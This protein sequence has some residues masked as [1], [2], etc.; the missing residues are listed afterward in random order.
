MVFFKAK[1][2]CSRSN[3]NYNTGTIFRNDIVIITKKKVHEIQ[4]DNQYLRQR[5]YYFAGIFLPVFFTGKNAYQIEVQDIYQTNQVS[6]EQ[7]K[8]KKERNKIK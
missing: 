7:K 6:K 3:S 1:A 8:I 5:A 2:Y 4:V